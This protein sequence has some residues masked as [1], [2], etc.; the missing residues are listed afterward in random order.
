MIHKFS[1]FIIEGLTDYEGGQVLGA[2]RTKADADAALDAYKAKVAA[3]PR[4]EFEFDGYRIAEFILDAA[5]NAWSKNLNL[6][7]DCKTIFN[8][9]P[10]WHL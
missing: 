2:Y 7:Y 8:L 6:H 9:Y 4:V 5:A 3:N 10:V 1:I